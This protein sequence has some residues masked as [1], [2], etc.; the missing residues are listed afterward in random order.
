MNPL[1]LCAAL[2][3]GSY[4]AQVL[5]MLE[6][7]QIKHKLVRDDEQ[8]ASYLHLHTSWG[9]RL[10]LTYTRGAAQGVRGA[11]AAQI[12]ASA[13]AEPQPLGL[14]DAA[15]LIASQ[16]VR[17][18]LHGE[19]QWRELVRR[20]MFDGEAREDR[21]GV[22]TGS[23]FGA[24]MAFD[25]RHG[26]PAFTSKALFWRGVVEE[27]AWFLRGSTDVRELQA[28]G[29]HIWDD[30]AAVRPDHNLGPIYGEQWRSW[31]DHG[32]V[33]DQIAALVHGL[34]TDPTSRRHVVS[35][36]N[37]S[38]LG[39]MA[40]APCHVLFQAHSH[41]PEAPNAPRGLSLQVYQRSADLFLGVPFNVASYAL[42][43][44]LLARWTG[45]TP[46]ELVWVGGD[47]HLYRSHFQAACEML[48][49][50]PRPLPSLALDAPLLRAPDVAPHMR[51]AFNVPASNL[52]DLSPE[53]ARLVSYDPWPAIKAPMAV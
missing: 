14:L 9:A 36:W 6:G 38:D 12:K 26:F 5:L 27:L 47:V 11:W 4:L 45:H 8:G 24:R 7:A 3:G 33:C 15:H 43:L 35:A 31:S 52:F 22:G 53:T 21:T 46:R 10:R 19:E 51:R 17:A 32:D 1:D 16:A 42:L 30:N 39:Q 2:E 41:E 13:E 34:L 18:V 40:L 29:V 49:R 25:L 50:P 37:V 44:A 28:R 20:A 23:I 48:A